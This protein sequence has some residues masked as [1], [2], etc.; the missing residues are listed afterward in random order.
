MGRV[1]VLL[2]PSLCLHFKNFTKNKQREYDRHPGNPGLEKPGLVFSPTERDSKRNQPPLQQGTTAGPNGSEA[3]PPDE[4]QDAPASKPGG[5]RHAVALK[6]LST[7]VSDLILAS[8]S[9]GTQTTYST[10]IK[11]WLS[12]CQDKGINDPYNATFQQGMDFLAFLFNKGT[13]YSYL[14]VIRSALSAVLPRRDGVT[15]GMHP[16]VARVVKGVFRTRPTIPKSSK[17]ITFDVGIVLNYITSLPDNGELLLEMLTKKTVTLLCL[18]SGQRSQTITSLRTSFMHKCKHTGKVSFAVPSLLKHSKPGR[19]QDPL[20]FLPYP[21]NAKICPVECLKTYLERT[22]L[23]RENSC[24][25]SQLIIS[26]F[27]PYRAVNS[28]TLARYVRSFFRNGW[29]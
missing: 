5:L 23:I 15:F 21:H 8:W 7:Q 20:E 24:E 3:A 19:H 11:K 4:P 18:L 29:H 28:Q 22:D 1:Q 13:K 26:Y 14:A 25:D 10:P 6:G 2:F 12:Y 9:E 17:V 16:D 27:Q